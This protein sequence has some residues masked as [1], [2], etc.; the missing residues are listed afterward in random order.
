MTP[1]RPSRPPS[2]RHRLIA[3]LAAAV[4]LAWGATAAF[5]YLDARHEIDAMLGTHLPATP[6]TEALHAALA[7]SIARHLLHPLLF[8]VPGLAV[9]IWLAVGVGLAPLGR[10]AGEVERR[11]PDNLAPLAL[12]RVPREVLPLQQALNALFARLRQ[13][14][15]LERR[16]TADA[17][18]ELRTPLAAIR[19]QAEVALNADDGAQARRALANVVGGAERA[20]RLVEQ[21]LTLAR[22]DP[23]TALERPQPIGLRAL[24][25]DAV[26]AQAPFAARRNIDLGLLPGEERTVHG[27]PLLLAV[28]LRNLVDNA[29]RY[30]PPGGRVDLAVEE[31]H[32][33]RGGYPL[34][35]VTDSG[36][37]IAPAAREQAF[38]RF[39]R[40]SDRREEG[41][42]LGLSIVRRIA[43]LHRAT[44]TLD[45]GPGGRGLTVRVGFPPAADGSA[46]L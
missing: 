15:E 33:A 28:L 43:E 9:A 27:D 7:E 38:E 32:A 30:T 4:L 26:A 2:L 36:P 46:P 14:R 34:L 24:A 6:A 39:H 31:A 42:G 23:Q 37:G 35:R 16:F 12:A 44:L 22:L 25:H 41:S 17:A 1:F 20:T 19:T 3:L 45:E 40:G 11:A 29:V 13:S 5:S 21:L 8:A 18:H 10:F